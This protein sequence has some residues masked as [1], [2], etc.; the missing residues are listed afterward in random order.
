MS[1]INF[2]IDITD[3][4]KSVFRSSLSFE[5]MASLISSMP[6]SSDYAEFYY[7]AAQNTSSQVRENVAY[8]DHLN[9]ETV[10]LLASD[11]S[12]NVLRNLTRS[13]GF[14]KYGTN[15]QILKFIDIDVEIAISIAANYEQYENIDQEQVLKK[16]TK[17]VD[18][19]V[20]NSIVSNWSAPKK[21]VKSFLNHNDLHVRA[22]AQRRMEQ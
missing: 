12:I 19:G 18:P 17:S 4:K 5:S 2:Y 6:D 3:G 7:Y 13:S 22:E 15:E 21:I 1:N 9:S 11:L 8:K 16:L 10:Q 14:K 20:I